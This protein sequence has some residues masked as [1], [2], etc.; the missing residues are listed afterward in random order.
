MTTSWDE[1]GGDFSN[2]CSYWVS[3]VKFRQKWRE[4][5]Q[6]GSGGVEMAYPDLGAAWAAGI[7][8]R[9]PAYIQTQAQGLFFLHSLKE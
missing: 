2:K 8:P 3:M 9:V 5:G 1:K 6:A 7:A 4:L